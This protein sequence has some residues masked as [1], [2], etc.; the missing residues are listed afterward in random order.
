MAV[1]ELSGLTKKYGDIAA[2]NNVS[3]SIKKGEIYGLLGP[4]GAG[5]TTLINCLCGLLV[6]NRGKILVFDK[7][8]HRSALEIK[9]RIGVVPQDLAIYEDLTAYE[10]IRFFAGLYGVS[11]KALSRSVEKALEFVGLEDSARKHPKTFSGGMKRR[12]NIACSVAHNPEIIIMD[13]PTVGVDPQSRSY[14]LRSVKKLCQEGCTIIYT[15]HYMEEA[16]GLCDRVGIMDH[17][18]VIAEGTIEELKGLIKNTSQVKIVFKESYPIDLEELKSVP[19][20]LDL[21]YS[22][23]TLILQNDKQMVDLDG[24]LE[25]LIQR[26]F[27]IR[28]VSSDSPSLETVFLSLTGRSLRD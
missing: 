21:E 1:I 27:S 18:K 10:N 22:D 24:V 26:K 12:L 3:L 16:E 17:G 9:A 2:V 6:S 4:N 15:T 11:G 28:A 19:G 5:K 20:I 13:E 25:F 8:F 23:H 7:D 14:I